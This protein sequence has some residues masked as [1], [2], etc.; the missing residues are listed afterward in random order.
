[1]KSKE[2]IKQ[3][4]IDTEQAYKQLKSNDKYLLQNGKIQINVIRDNFSFV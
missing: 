4:L 1:M 3:M 2:E